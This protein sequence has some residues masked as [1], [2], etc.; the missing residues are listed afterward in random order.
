M[1]VSRLRLAAGLLV[2]GIAGASPA[3]AGGAEAQGPGPGPWSLLPALVAI[4]LALVV[5]QVL[6]ALF[7]GI[8]VGAALLEGRVGGAFS[9]SLDVVIA[10]LADADHVKVMVFTLLMGGLVGLISDN[11]GARGLLAW[12]Q[13]RA[14]TPQQ[15]MLTTWIL[16]MLVFIDDYAS[17]LLVGSTMRPVTDRLRISR[18]KLAYI[19]DSTSAPI[20][21]LALVSTWVGYELSVLQDALTASDVSVGAYEVFVSGLPSRFYPWL[22]LAMVGIVAVTGRDFGPMWRAEQ[23][24]RTTGAVL[25]PGGT[26]LMDAETFGDDGSARARPWLGAIPILV[27]LVAVGGVLTSTGLEAVRS[28]PVGWSTTQSQGALRTLG[29]VLGAA[30]SFDALVY[31]SALAVIVGLVL[32]IGTRSLGLEPAVESVLR[33]M[34]ATLVAVVVLV[35]AWGIGDV[36]SRLQAGPYVAAALGPAVPA[37]T[38]PTLV[39]VSAGL[40]AFATGTSWGTMAILFP[41]IVPVVAVH[42]A[43]TWFLPLLVSSSS[44]VLA[45]AVFGDHCSPISDTTILSSVACAADH[46]DHVRTQAPYALTVAL[47]SVVFGTFPVGLGL[48]PGW[49]LGLG[50]VALVVGMRRFGRKTTNDT[51]RNLPGDDA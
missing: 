13:H 30:S 7:A 15:G 2:L 16:G 36:M 6:V 25:R 40:L 8:L 11:G 34:R 47:V 50:F 1:S 29:A 51:P 23:R 45:G 33:G 49:G 41:V 27:L 46:V 10:A 3:I 37:W 42:Q 48:G 14:R 28:D 24:A 4:V 39:F 18:E 21:S 31:G 12:A 43:E 22:A 44:S 19:V 32:T 9:S 20:T 5:R 35:L 38:L 26:A 17:T